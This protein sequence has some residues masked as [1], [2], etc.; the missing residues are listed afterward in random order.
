MILLKMKVNNNN[1]PVEGESLVNT[2]NDCQLDTS[3]DINA[4]LF[5][6][7]LDDLEFEPEYI[8]DD[9]DIE[10]VYGFNN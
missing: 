10:D 2:G 5:Y 6:T 7:D 3:V 1:L 8:E 4:E 9:N